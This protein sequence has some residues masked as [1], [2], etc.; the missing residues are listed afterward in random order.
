MPS[1]RVGI[2]KLAYPPLVQLPRLT[3]LTSSS[4]EWRVIKLTIY[5]L[6]A[7]DTKFGSIAEASRKHLGD[8]AGRHYSS[9]PQCLDAEVL[10]YG[11]QVD[12]IYTDF[13]KAFDTVP[14]RRLLKG[15]ERKGRVFI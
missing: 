9:V 1:P 5:L 4:V 15:K 7:S 8:I 10:D 6:S 11:G 13:A 3:I 12:V 14:H 2:R